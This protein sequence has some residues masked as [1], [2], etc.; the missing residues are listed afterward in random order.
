LKTRRKRAAWDT[1]YLAQ[2]LN[3]K[4]P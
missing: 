2:I 1:N 4:I 3:M